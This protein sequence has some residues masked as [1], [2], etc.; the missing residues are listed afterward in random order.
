MA[1]RAQVINFVRLG[2]LDEPNEVG[3]IGEVAVMQDE[4]AVIQVRVLVD[5]V[6]PCCIEQAGS[7]LDAMHQIAFGQ[8]KLGQ[9]R[10]VL[11]CDARDKGGFS[12]VLPMSA[13]AGTVKPGFLAKFITPLFPEVS[14]RVVELA[15]NAC[16]CGGISIAQANNANISNTDRSNNATAK[17][18]EQR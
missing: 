10:A 6:H 17:R 12:L 7:A 18:P 11:P 5:M 1:L 14:G 16:R 13:S 4:I 2:L 15:P 8:Q 3:A 9:V